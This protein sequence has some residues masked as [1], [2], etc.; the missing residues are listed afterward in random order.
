VQGGG[1]SSIAAVEAWYAG[2]VGSPE[3][4]RSLRDGSK[5]MPDWTHPDVITDNLDEI[6]AHFEG[7]EGLRRWARESFAIMD[8]GYLELQEL[9]P[10]TPDVVVSV[11]LVRGKM[12]ETGIDPHF[13]LHTVHAFRDGLSV[14]A[15]GFADREA[16]LE[17]AR[18]WPEVLTT[19]SR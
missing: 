10:V 17:F 2:Y 15:K 1:L 14:Y 8:D 3:A 13:P 5:P 9:I 19:R 6:P 18:A 4:M 7:H 11:A 12:K 16:A